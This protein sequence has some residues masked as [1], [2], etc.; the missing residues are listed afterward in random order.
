MRRAAATLLPFVLLAALW[1]AL[2]EARLVDP[3]VLPSA[4]TVFRALLDQSGGNELYLD[5]A[6][7]LERCLLGLAAGA[8]VGVPLGALMA[9]SPAAAGFFG[10][11]IRATYALP[12]TAV[13]PLFILWFGVGLR[14]EIVAVVLSALLPIT[15][16]TYHGVQS[17]PQMI[18]WS[19]RAMGTT[20]RTMFWRVLLPGSL[21]ATL[22]GLRIALGFS[23]VV[24]IA[25]E[26]LA[27]NDGIGKRIF[28]FGETGAYDYM[29]AAI[30]LLIA[31]A[32]LL[33]VGFARASGFWLR[34]H[35]AADHDV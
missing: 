1:Q 21:H 2:A 35:G 13:V 10:P 8:A 22:A 15:I 32:A 3:A 20:R 27:S 24:A 28:V 30:L 33:D 14:T 11:L 16:Y 18:V 7:T 9:V 23:F 4:W 19:A 34:W 17:V 31:V 26:M 25:T 5:L 6:V 12:K 29:F